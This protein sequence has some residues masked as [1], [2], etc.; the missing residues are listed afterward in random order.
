MHDWKQA[1]VL[2]KFEIRESKQIF[3][4]LFLYYC[5]F[6]SLFVSVSYLVGEFYFGG[7]DIFYLLL[8]TFVPFWIKPKE[9]QYQRTN[10]GMWASPSVIM[11]TQLPINREIIIKSRFIQ[12]FIYSFPFQLFLLVSLY[13]L[14][15]NMQ[16]NMSPISYISFS[17]IWL[18]FGVYAGL[19]IV[20]TDAGDKYGKGNRK[21]YMAFGFGILLAVILLILCFGLIFNYGIV[22]WTIIF[23]QKWP[24]ISSAISILLVFL[25]FKHAQNHMKKTMEKVDYF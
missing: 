25:G 7:L 8:F 19:S 13:L 11:L 2:A 21:L 1:F 16:T 5:L 20:T 4:Y 23:A 9:F 24:L 6:I 3:I 12:Y 18:S 15:P 17:V 22:H 10:S 14:T